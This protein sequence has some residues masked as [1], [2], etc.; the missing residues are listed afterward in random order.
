MGTCVSKSEVEQLRVEVTQLT[1]LLGNLHTELKRGADK[2]AK[3]DT[4]L[5]AD[6]VATFRAWLRD[7]PETS[8]RTTEFSLID[9]RTTDFSLIERPLSPRGTTVRSSLVKGGSINKNMNRATVAS[10]EERSTSETPPKAHAA[11][12]ESSWTLFF[13][14]CSPP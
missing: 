7:R 4:T 11:F 14:P 1:D 9:S 3:Y 5:T 10:L 6:D 2:E 12:S 13:G 8:E